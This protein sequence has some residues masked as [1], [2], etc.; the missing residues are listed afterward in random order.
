MTMIPSCDVRCDLRKAIEA[1]ED[2]TLEYSPEYKREGSIYSNPL[3]GAHDFP[4]LASYERY[5][6]RS[7]FTN[8]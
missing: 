6:S 1:Q 8:A 7:N 5:I 3:T 2:E 4:L